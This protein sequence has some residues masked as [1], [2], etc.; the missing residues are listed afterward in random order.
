[1]LAPWKKSFDKLRQYIKK[2]RHH[3]ANKGLFSQSY[4]FFSSHVSMWELDH[5]VWVPKIWCFQTVVLEKT[6]ESPL[7]CN[8]IKPVNLKGNQSWIFNIRTDAEADTPVL[9]LHDAKS[10]FTGK[11]SDAGKGRGQEKKQVTEDEMV[12]WHHGLNEHESEQPQKRM[13][14]REAWHAAVYGLKESLSDWTDAEYI[15]WNARLHNSSWNEDFWEKYQQ[16]QIWRWYHSNSR[17]QSG[18]KEL[19]DES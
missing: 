11:D 6:P 9:W 8:E 4:V 18:T 17:K 15:M 14:D 12:G 3:F 16:S 5:E 2:Q 1:M 7:D 10:W 13:K 19:L